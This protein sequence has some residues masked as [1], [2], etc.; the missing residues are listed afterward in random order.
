MKKLVSLILVSL[1][2]FS[3]SSAPHH[4]LPKH[5]SVTEVRND[6]VFICVSSR[7][8]AYHSTLICRGLQRCTHQIIKIS[9]YDA[10]NKYGYR[11]CKICE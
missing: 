1:S 6:S 9:L 10:V 4:Q 11:A 3:F 5:S 2:F 8:Y 7:A